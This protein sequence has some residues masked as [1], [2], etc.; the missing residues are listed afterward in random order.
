MDNLK[1]KTLLP[2]KLQFFAE[3]PVPAPE[4][5]PAPE[6]TPEPTLSAEE[7]LAKVMA[8]N[9]R[10]KAAT[11]KATSEAAENKRK[12]REKMSEQEKFDAEKLERE[13]K[14]QAEFEQL[15]RENSINKMSK[16]FIAMGY[17][18]EQALK[19]SEAQIDGDT[20]ELFRIQQAFLTERDKA[21]EA[22]WMKNLP[23]P[24]SGNKDTVDDAFIKG[25]D[26]G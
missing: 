22:E 10:L 18:E 2:Y 20:D 17:T 19:A 3:D 21:K 4:S 13:T 11:D 9:K 25:F 15:K 1:K 7:Q 14:F 16:S 24:P 8:E 5:D 23:T 6:S 12:L 26:K